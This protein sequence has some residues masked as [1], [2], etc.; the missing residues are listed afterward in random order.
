MLRAILSNP[1]E[2]AETRRE[3]RKKN[4]TGQKSPVKTHLRCIN[5][6]ITQYWMEKSNMLQSKVT[7]FSPKK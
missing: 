4:T 3:R 6:L 5:T 7:V 2:R 1:A